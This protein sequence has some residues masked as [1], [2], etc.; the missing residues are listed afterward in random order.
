MSDLLGRRVGMRNCTG[1]DG[2]SRGSNSIS[3]SISTKRE[4]SSPTLKSC[5][6]H[7]FAFYLRCIPH[8]IAIFSSKIE[9]KAMISIIPRQSSNFPA[10]KPTTP[11]RSLHLQVPTRHS[12]SGPRA[13]NASDGPPKLRHPDKQCKS[14][15]SP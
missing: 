12:M 6:P 5:G 11:S 1:Q 3:F 15:S 7:C 8:L 13:K 10:A 2:Q 14:L 4:E 9:K